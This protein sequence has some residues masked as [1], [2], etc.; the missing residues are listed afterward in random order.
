MLEMGAGVRAAFYYYLRT[1]FS[2]RR[3]EIPYRLSDF[4][5]AV[6]ALFGEGGV[7]LERAIVKRFY[8]KLGV[9]LPTQA[10][11]R[12]PFDFIGLIRMAG[13]RDV[14]RPRGWPAIENFLAKMEAREHVLLLYTDQEDKRRVLYTFLRVG[15]ERGEVG[16][17]VVSQETPEQAIKGIKRF[18]IDVDRY[19]RE[20]ALKVI[21]YRDWYLRGGLFD[22]GR[23]RRLWEAL[24]TTTV[25][26][27]FRGLRV[28]GEMAAFFTH[29]LLRELADYERSLQPTLAIPMR[30]ICAYDKRLLAHQG[31]VN[32]LLDLLGSHSTTIIS[33]PEAGLLRAVRPKP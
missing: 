7:V 3:E 19:L 18:G 25:E 5:R 21:D 33:G 13:Q 15:L 24:Y 20:G 28:T 12:V 23:T 14:A 6:L 4:H 11:R 9:P 22:A 17:Y 32:L 30:A 27:G 10:W 26:Q 29:H 31:D 8:S 1:N 2:L 16:A